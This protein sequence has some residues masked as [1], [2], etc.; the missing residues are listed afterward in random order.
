[1]CADDC[2]LH[3]TADEWTAKQQEDHEANVVL[4]AMLQVALIFMGR[5][6]DYAA[7]HDLF[8]QPRWRAALERYH[9]ML[10]TLVGDVI[11]L[12]HLHY[13]PREGFYESVARHGPDAALLNLYMVSGSNGA[14]H[15]D[16]E[17]LGLSQ[18]VNSK[19]HFARTA[20]VAG[21]PVPE[22]L[23]VHCADVDGP[24]VAAFFEDY[25][26]PA[27]LMIKLLGLAGAR[28]V[29][30]VRSVAEARAFVQTFDGAVEVLLQRR[31]DTSQYTEMTVD[32]C[33]RDDSVAITNVRQIL[34]ADGLWVGNYISDALQ[35]TAR[36]QERCLQVGRYVQALGYCRPEG[37][38]CGIDFF[39]PTDPTDEDLIVIEIN[40]R[41]TGGL[42]PA[43]LLERL[44]ARA[45]DSIAFIDVI[46][47]AQLESY[48]GFLEA[49]LEGAAFRIAPMGFSPFVQKLDDVD[50]LY[51]WQIVIGDFEL[52]KAAKLAA[53][54]PTALP[55]ADLIARPGV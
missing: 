48:L 30:V 19:M 27:G 1:M 44:D 35:L 5:S 37:L 18:R 51:V 42:F 12:D 16:P 21:I 54:G 3:F 14:L 24:A 52:F 25:G 43:H 23:V 36:Q 10:T 33:V 46:P 40:A 4:T 17:A 45:S 34:F 38:N 28:N 53:L 6:K 50:S 7:L 31:L 49:H 11:P 9:S 20:P 13:H 55:T 2:L 29:A 15:N 32:L 22:T 41:W 39:V 8:R 47:E 26:E